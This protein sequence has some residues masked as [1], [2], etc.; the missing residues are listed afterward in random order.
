MMAL[1]MVS[2]RALTATPFDP[3]SLAAWGAPTPAALPWVAPTTPLAL[4][5]AAL[6]WAGLDTFQGPA[7]ASAASSAT[8]FG[9]PAFPG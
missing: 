8:P 4:S 1:V 3:S 2:F 6:A 7:A 9:A 5:P